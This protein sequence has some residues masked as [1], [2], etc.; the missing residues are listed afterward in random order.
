[1]NISQAFMAKNSPQQLTASIRRQ[2]NADHWRSH[3]FG[4]M[5]INA[6]TV[7]HPNASEGRSQARSSREDFHCK[8]A[9]T[10]LARNTSR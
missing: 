5:G 9:V 10:G 6:Y 1:M 3:L 8:E 2:I 7:G 4:D